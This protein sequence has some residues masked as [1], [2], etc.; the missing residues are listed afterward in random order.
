MEGRRI[1]TNTLHPNRSLAF[2]SV[3]EDGKTSRL[4]WKPSF[5]DPPPL[6]H[7]S[8]KKKLNTWKFATIKPRQLCEYSLPWC[9]CTHS[10]R[11]QSGEDKSDQPLSVQNPDSIVPAS[12]H[13]LKRSGCQFNASGGAGEHGHP[14]CSCPYSWKQ[15]WRKLIQSEQ[16][17][18]DLCLIAPC[19]GA[20]GI[21][22]G[23]RRNKEARMWPNRAYRRL[24]RADSLPVCCCF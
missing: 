15:Q 22:E 11:A 16:L 21:T 23:P 2:R 24:E 7:L 3:L 1:T 6:I 19:M 17:S 13:Q 12:K 9:C 8:S 5:L 18:C 20:G 10:S 4:H 14:L